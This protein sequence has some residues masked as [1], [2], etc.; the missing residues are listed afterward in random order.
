MKRR[1]LYHAE[2]ALEMKRRE[3]DEFDKV[4]DSTP[5]I[6]LR[7]LP[8]LLGQIKA[9]EA[10]VR[11][12]RAQQTRNEAAKIRKN[13]ATTVCESCGWSYSGAGAAVVQCHN[14]IPV[15]LGGDNSP[16]NLAILCPN[17]RAV[18]HYLTDCADDPPHDRDDLL[19]RLQNLPG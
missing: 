9:L 18:A 10:L 15:A 17:C 11:K 7:R 3:L 2:L 8:L 16:H 1:M 12:G 4:Y 6:G 13:L 5:H 14:V 19:A